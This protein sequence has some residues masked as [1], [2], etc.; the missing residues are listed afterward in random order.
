[1]AHDARAVANE[2][3]WR[4][5]RAGRPVTPLAAIKLVYFSHAWMMALHEDDLIEEDVEAWKYG[6]VIPS[7]YHAI[8]GHGWRPV[9]ERIRGVRRADFNQTETDIIDQV[10][11][12]YGKFSGIYLS[13]LTHV[14]DAP[15]TKNWNP[16]E[17]NIVIPNKQIKDYYHGEAEKW[18]AATAS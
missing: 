18:R 1:M 16:E 13:S 2:F 9:L 15:W 8:K 6:P 3:I 12:K 17:K 7:V 5:V 10:W 4:G 11:R 14:P